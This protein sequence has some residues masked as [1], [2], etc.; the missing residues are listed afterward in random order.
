MSGR[1]AQ[2]WMNRVSEELMMACAPELGV[3]SQDGGAPVRG[4]ARAIDEEHWDKV[5]RRF[6]LS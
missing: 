3:V 6:L 1:M 5:A 2:A 4:L